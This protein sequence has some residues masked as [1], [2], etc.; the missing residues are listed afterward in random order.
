MYWE[1]APPLRIVSV[2]TMFTST[3]DLLADFLLCV[4]I[5]Q[6][7]DHFE[8]L[9]ARLASYG[10]FLFT[11]VSVIVYVAEMVSE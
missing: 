8:T 4:R 10:Y 3:L 2:V 7:M 9:E 5:H 11:G 1:K 6:V